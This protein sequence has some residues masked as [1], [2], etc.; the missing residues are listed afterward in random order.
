ML[1]QLHPRLQRAIYHCGRAFS[2]EVDDAHVPVAVAIVNEVLDDET[3]DPNQES[4]RGWTA[5]FYAA[6][7][8]ALQLEVLDVFI[9]H[10][11]VDV[12]HR[13]VDGQTVLHVA[14]IRGLDG[15]VVR[16]L[17]WHD[18]NSK[19]VHVRDETGRTPLSWAAGY[20]H[21]EVVRHIVDN[22][23]HSSREGDSNGREPL[24]YSAEVGCAEAVSFLIRNAP[25]SVG[26]TDDDGRT[27]ISWVAGADVSRRL[28]TEVIELLN[29]SRPNLINAP[30]RGGAT[31]LWWA[32][33][34]RNI[35]AIR[36]LI[37]LQPTL[38][39]LEERGANDVLLLEL[40]L[41]TRDSR[42]YSPLL[43]NIPRPWA[44]NIVSAM[45]TETLVSFIGCISS[46]PTQDDSP[47]SAGGVLEEM[48]NDG[49]TALHEAV[50]LNSVSKVS[51]LLDAKANINAV[52]FSGRTPLHEAAALG[53]MGI[54][55]MLLE[56]E[57]KADL[58]ARDSSG[59]TPLGVALENQKDSVIELLLDRSATLDGLTSRAWRNAYYN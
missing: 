30:D 46:Y 16:L 53:Q 54:V 32:I 47:D 52:D 19:L 48:D 41:E 31:P 56:P 6:T 34:G 4:G 9:N 38:N 43:S 50:K 17:Q 18:A 25:E 21:T 20:G 42:I 7:A 22:Y 49:C 59:Q 23:P 26:S 12:G 15:V 57:Y 51:V 39:F 29:T 44:H 14:A 55:Q 33:N 28:T 45:R 58:D 8:Q 2:L 3:I 5:L 11:R 24:S 27:P 35:A 13:D 37:R 1:D 10:P 40:A 36:T